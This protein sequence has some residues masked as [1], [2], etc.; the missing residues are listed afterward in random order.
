MPARELG[1]V[2][3]VQAVGRLS[4]ADAFLVLGPGVALLP[5]SW[6]WVE[7]FGKAAGWTGWEKRK[8][9]ESELFG[10]AKLLG[11]QHI[12]ELEARQGILL[13]QSGEGANSPLVGWGLEGSAMTFAPPRTGKGA[14]DRPQ[15]PGASRARLA[16][17]DG[18]A[19]SPGG[20]LVRRRPPPAGDGARDGAAR[21]LRRGPAVQGEF[22]RARG[23]RDP[24]AAQPAGIP[25]PP[26][27][28]DGFRPHGHRVRRP[29]RQR[30]ARRAAH[31]GRRAGTTPACISTIPR[32]P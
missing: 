29:R 2:R 5:L 32:A 21:S 17:L 4:A 11:R 7:W 15:L 8:R 3:F 12:R 18:A 24:G 25:E 14:N 27:Q 30:A 1:V 20:D 16:G 6:V 31:A 28:P 13:G 19:G 26:L 9:S 22:R 10:K 23:R